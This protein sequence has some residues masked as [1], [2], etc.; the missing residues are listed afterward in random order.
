MS[1]RF[2]ELSEVLRGCK[3]VIKKFYCSLC[4]ADK[5]K[6]ATLKKKVQCPKCNLARQLGCKGLESKLVQ[7]HLE[8]LTVWFVSSLALNMM[9]QFD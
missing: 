4:V 5:F 2:T 3:W 8:N 6:M 1:Q 9:D 7:I